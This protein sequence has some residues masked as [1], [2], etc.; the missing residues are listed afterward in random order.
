MSTVGNDPSG[1]DLIPAADLIS[2][3]R[4]RVENDKR[5][6]EVARE[7]ISADERSYQRQVES[8]DNQHAREIELRNAY[9][10]THKVV[11]FS[12]VL[13]S[14]SILCFLLYNAFYGE[15]QQKEYGLIII[16]YLAIGLAGYGVI[17]GIAGLFKKFLKQGGE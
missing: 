8:L 12:I 14:F 4:A 13:A 11:L 17:S 3:E 10:K 15:G 16:K 6:I 1:Q 5:E 9:H 7:A 2:L